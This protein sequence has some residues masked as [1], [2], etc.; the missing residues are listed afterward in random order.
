MTT[1]H[2]ATSGFQYNVAIN[3]KYIGTIGG[4]TDQVASANACAKFHAAENDCLVVTRVELGRKHHAD[5]A[6]LAKAGAA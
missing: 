5:V 2:T 6:A 3:G 4:M 1:A